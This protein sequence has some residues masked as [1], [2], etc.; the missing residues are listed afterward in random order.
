MAT[1]LTRVKMADMWQAILIALFPTLVWLGVTFWLRTSGLS[2]G[3]ISIG[4]LWGVVAGLASLAVQ[5]FVAPVLTSPNRW[6]GDFLNSFVVAALVEETIKYACVAA[7]VIYFAKALKLKELSTDKRDVVAIAISVAIGFMSLENLWAVFNADQPLLR[8]RDRLVSIFAG[9][10]AFQ[11]M[12]GYWL[13]KA[14]L[15]RRR[16]SWLIAL[17]IPV[18]VHGFIN[19]TEEL[20]RDE[21]EH[22]SLEDTVLFTLWIGALIATAVVTPYLVWKTRKKNGAVVATAP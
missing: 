15:N 19:V 22:G 8:A 3:R 17:A 4:L 7:V 21:P 16:V 2:I 1:Y 12:M 13:A 18:F 5:I 20:F 10:P 9:H 6:V 11:V 14:I